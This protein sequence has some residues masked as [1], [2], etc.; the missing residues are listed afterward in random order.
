MTE[1]SLTSLEP[2]YI[3]NQI[4]RIKGILNSMQGEDGKPLNDEKVLALMS[5]TIDTYNQ[6]CNREKKEREKGLQKTEIFQA[7]MKALDSIEDYGYPNSSEMVSVIAKEI[8]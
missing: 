1:L 4:N 3:K 6:L 7:E 8:Y 2:G 5:I